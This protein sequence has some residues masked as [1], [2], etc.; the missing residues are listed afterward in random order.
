VGAS[1]DKLRMR[2]TFA[3]NDR[4]SRGFLSRGLVYGCGDGLERGEDGCV[5]DGLIGYGL[6]GVVFIVAEEFVE[7]AGGFAEGCEF[8]DCGAGS[9]GA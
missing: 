2:A 4:V 5:F 7:E 8:F 9:E 6:D 1:F 3:Q